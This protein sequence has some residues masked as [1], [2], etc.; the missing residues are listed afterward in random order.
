[1]HALLIK[2]SFVAVRCSHFIPINTFVQTRLQ[3]DH[4]LRGP[5]NE[6]HIDNVILYA[7]VFVSAWSKRVMCMRVFLWSFVIFCLRGLFSLSGSHNFN[8]VE[9]CFRPSIASHPQ[10]QHVNGYYFFSLVLYFRLIQHHT[11]QYTATTNLPK[12]THTESVQGIFES[13]AAG[14]TS[15]QIQ[16]TY[17]FVS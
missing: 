1:M 13:H 8:L 2:F 5:T 12:A 11:D 9:K 3:R 4:A 10:Q 6:L 14:T 17:S 15:L 16:N 7:Y